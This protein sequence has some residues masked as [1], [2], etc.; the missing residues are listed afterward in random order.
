MML[1]SKPCS[2]YLITTQIHPPCQSSRKHWS[3]GKERRKSGITHYKCKKWY[4]VCCS[5]LET[6]SCCL[7]C[8]L[9]RSSIQMRLR[10]EAIVAVLLQVLGLSKTP[11]HGLHPGSFVYLCT[12]I[13]SCI[14]LAH[15][16][17]FFHRQPVMLLIILG[18]GIKLFHIFL[19]CGNIMAI[20]K[21]KSWKKSWRVIKYD[22]WPKEESNNIMWSAEFRLSLS[23]IWIFF[24]CSNTK[25][26]GQWQIFGRIIHSSGNVNHEP[27]M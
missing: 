11:K 23:Q 9:S 22:T 4:R 19:P 15:R 27:G 8:L 6:T 13:N 2:W 24:F 12:S 1:V 17:V 26:L 25:N 20:L 3:L 14:G 18:W 10:P 21:Q 5:L 7:F 16:V